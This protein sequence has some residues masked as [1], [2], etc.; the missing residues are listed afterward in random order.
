MADIL[1]PIFVI[2]MIFVLYYVA[3][4]LDSLGDIKKSKAEINIITAQTKR[5]EINL[6]KREVELKMGQLAIEAKKLEQLE[7]NEPNVTE[8]NYHVVDK[9]EHKKKK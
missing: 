7:F 6:R 8:A 9:L 2:V 5:E 4:N 1:G 3:Q